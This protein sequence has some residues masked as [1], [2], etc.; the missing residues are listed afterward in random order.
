MKNVEHARALQIALDS[1]HIFC[2]NNLHTYK[3]QVWK[4]ITAC[5]WTYSK[6]VLII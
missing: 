5:I 1:F 2:T 4:E 3:I 6:N